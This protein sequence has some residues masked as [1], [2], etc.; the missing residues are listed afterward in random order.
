MLPTRPSFVLVLVFI[1]STPAPVLAQD[2]PPR[3]GPFVLDGRGTVP[4]FPRDQELAASRGLAT[5]ELPGP[6]IGVD[7]G[8]HFYL[9]TWKAVTF[10]LGAQLTL[11]RSHAGGDEAT[12]L[13]AVTERFI[14]FTPQLSLNFGTGNGW[15]YL[16]G[17]IGSARMSIVPDGEA[18]APADLTA[19]RT[20]NYGGGARW[21]IRPRL[22][23]TLD[24]RFHQLDPGPPVS[25]LPGTPR[26]TFMVFGAGVSFK[27]WQGRPTR[28]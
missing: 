11:G 9:L 20:V 18:E 23:F 28:P 8:A 5:S 3:I 1:M 26:L 10:G 19:V 27:P 2:P 25:D 14:S 6:G 24:V 7:A 15:S 21:F 16:S 4:A 22:A 12:L 17:G 13:R